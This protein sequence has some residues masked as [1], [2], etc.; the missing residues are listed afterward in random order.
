MET[1]QRVRRVETRLTQLMIA[2]GVRTD[3]QQPVFADGAVTIPSIHASIKE[4]IDSV[5]P[6]WQKPV[7]IFIGTDQVAVISR[8]GG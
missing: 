2:M 1:L 7:G 4:I 8:P 6:D 5:P 3:A